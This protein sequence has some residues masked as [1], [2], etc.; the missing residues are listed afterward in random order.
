[1]L[2]TDDFFFDYDFDG[3]ISD[4]SEECDSSEESDES[5]ES[6]EIGNN[7]DV[8]DDVLIIDFSDDE[9]N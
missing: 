6:D 7:K 5:A 8:D 3:I 1:M 9:V 4:S 2:L